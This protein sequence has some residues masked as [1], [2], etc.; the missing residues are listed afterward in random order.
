ME[1]FAVNLTLSRHLYRTNANL[2]VQRQFVLDTGVVRIE[3]GNDRRL[4]ESGY[5]HDN[6]V[7]V[8][9]LGDQWAGLL[10]AQTSTRYTAQPQ[11]GLSWTRQWLA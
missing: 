5:Q 11:P 1:D 2:G 10:G 3:G 6:H 7:A 9:A 8:Q 4:D